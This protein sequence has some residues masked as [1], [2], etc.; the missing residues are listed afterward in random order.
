MMIKNI[1]SIT[2]AFSLAASL[3]GAEEKQ[4]DSNEFEVSQSSE[5]PP[6]PK[7]P[8]PPLVRDDKT[9]I[10]YDPT[11]KL[12]WQDDVEAKTTRKKFYDEGLFSNS[13]PAQDYCKNLKLGGYSDW[14]LPDIKEFSSITDTDKSNLAIKIGFKNLIGKMYWSSSSKAGYKNLNWQIEFESG[15]TDTA[16]KGSS[17]F[18][19]CVR[20]SK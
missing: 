5:M 16:N 12:M 7:P 2:L 17:H 15:H 8:V 3:Y 10:V 19:R 4:T 11:T 20:E 1:L 13:Y 14:R 9:E 18:I 6:A